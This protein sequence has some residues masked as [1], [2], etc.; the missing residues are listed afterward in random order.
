MDHITL[1]TLAGLGAVH[2]LNP[3]MGWLFA[4]FAGLQDRSRASL[5]RSLIPIAIGHELSIAVTVLIIEVSAG[6][7]SQQAVGLAGAVV[8]VAFGVWKLA[9]RRSHPR[10]VGMRLSRR[11][12]ATWSFLMSTAHGAG[13]MLLPAVLRTGTHENIHDIGDITST[14]IAAAGVHTL[15]MIVVMGT[16]AVLVFELA[17]LRLLRTRWVNLDRVWAAGLV[18]AGVVTIFAA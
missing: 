6:V 16:V 5:L 4:V 17:G 13:L 18:A 9:A 14:A 7:V 8:L 10:W 12:L 11:E 1:L 15:A 2:G 3:A